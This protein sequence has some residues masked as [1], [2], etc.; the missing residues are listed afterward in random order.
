MSGEVDEQLKCPLNPR[1]GRPNTSLQNV[2][3]FLGERWVR[4]LLEVSLHR[5][6]PS[7]G[8][9]APQRPD[10]NTAQYPNSTAASISC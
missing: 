1:F 4:V 3:R 8:K 6:M 5:E 7:F 10:S 2:I 9:S